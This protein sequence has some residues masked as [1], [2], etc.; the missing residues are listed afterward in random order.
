MPSRHCAIATSIS[1]STTTPPPSS[2]SAGN[3]NETL[4]DAAAN[5]AIAKA[6]PAVALAAINA[7][8]KALPAVWTP[9]TTG[10]AHLYLADTSGKGDAS[11]RT[12]LL[13]DATIAD[14]L[15]TKPD[16]THQLT[17]QAWF[18]YAARDGQ[19]RS[20]LLAPATQPTAED[21]LAADLEYS[22]NTT[23]YNALAQTYGE[24]G[25]PTAALAELD[26]V[27][28]LDPHSADT[29]DARAVILWNTNR[30]DEAI[31]SWRDA[32]ASLRIIEDRAAA[33]ETFWSGFARIARHLRD[34]GLGTQLKPQMDDV[35]RV[36]LTRNGNYRAPELLQAAF[37]SQPDPAAGAAWII[38]LASVA[39]DPIAVLSGI[40]NAAWLSP[41]AHETILLREIQLAQ[42]GIKGTTPQASDP[43][44]ALMFRAQQELIKLYVAAA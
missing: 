8:G 37:M 7:R 26:H 30:H 33:P 12:I 24:A 4:S 36:Y 21:L 39:V 10:L 43:S 34:H 18:Y 20:S 15:A 38:S 42:S 9:A 23:S 29:Q 35:L 25:N 44:S 40:D 3:R 22:A 41:A 32:L 13:S 11:L 5:L 1:C 17:G 19:L 16:T 28:E 31:A 14:R 2:R 27:L 6:S